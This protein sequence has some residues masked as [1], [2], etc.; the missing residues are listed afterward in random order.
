M[1]WRRVRWIK[2]TTQ[3]GLSPLSVFVGHRMRMRSCE[4]NNAV[5]LTESI[6]RFALPVVDR[7][8]AGDLLVRLDLEVDPMTFFD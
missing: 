6:C 3:E 5:E 4:C 8:M 1:R 7:F 2:Q